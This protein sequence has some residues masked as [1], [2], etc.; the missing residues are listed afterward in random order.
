MRISIKRSIILLMMLLLSMWISIHFNFSGDLYGLISVNI[1]LAFVVIEFFFHKRKQNL[2]QM[3]LIR[4][5][6]NGLLKKLILPFIGISILVLSQSS[7]M[8]V[9]YMIELLLLVFSGLF[10]VSESTYQLD[11]EG[12]YDI[13]KEQLIP[14]EE[15]TKIEQKPNTIAVHTNSHHNQLIIKKSKLIQP[16]WDD[17]NNQLKELTKSLNQNNASKISVSNK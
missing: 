12:F 13:D 1:I 5:K 17:L 10:I 6:S 11:N 9:I 4:F 15:I 16:A 7:L 14:F 2:N 8:E 3:K